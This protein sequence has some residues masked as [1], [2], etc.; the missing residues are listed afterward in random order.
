MIGWSVVVS[1]FMTLPDGTTREEK[2]KVTYKP[3]PRRV[4]VHPCRIPKGEKGLHGRALPRAE[5]R[6]DRGRGREPQ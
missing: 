5:R 3:K 1:R 4:E 2:R 6:G